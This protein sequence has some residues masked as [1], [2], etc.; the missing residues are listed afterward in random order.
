[1]LII[2][3]Y[4]ALI[5]FWDKFCKSFPIIITLSHLLYNEVIARWNVARELRDGRSKSFGK[6]EVK[7]DIAE[8]EDDV[9][10]LPSLDSPSVLWGILMMSLLLAIPDGLS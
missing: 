7:L 4:L 8:E 2:Y 5:L 10:S 1:M 3:S 9:G 6:D